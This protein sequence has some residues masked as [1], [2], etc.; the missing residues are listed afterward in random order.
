ML[1]IYSI[2][3]SLTENRI[4]LSRIVAIFVFIL[5][6]TTGLV[7]RLI[8]LQVVGHEQY[9][10]MATKNRIKLTPVTPTRGIIYDR[11]GQ[12]LAENIPT[13]TLEL[14]L[15]QISDLDDT[16][17]KL[18]TLLT[19]PD[20][21]VAQFHQQ[22]KR[23]KSFNTIPL[24]LRMT[25]EQVAKF[26]VVRHSFPGVDIYAG[27]LRRYPYSEIT[28]H[29]V[30]YLGRINE[31]ELKSLPEAE[32]RGTHH[33]GKAGIEKHY[34]TILHGTTSYAE[35]ETNAQGR[36]YK[37]PKLCQPKTGFKPLSKFRYW[38]TTNRL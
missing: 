31:R 13:Y 30:G 38:T 6:L 28:S 29:V 3:D 34:E 27:L 26:A 25:D 10:S 32:Y 15:E 4:F 18:Q 33:I 14:I 2:K 37:Y 8:Y 35:V 21:K 17:Q 9:A 7:I 22:R 5:L 19:I 11:K 16:L 1:S 24:L 12:I 23:Q 36:G 20:D